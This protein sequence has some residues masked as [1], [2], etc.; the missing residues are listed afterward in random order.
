MALFCNGRR[1]REQGA[2]NGYCTESFHI[3][4]IKGLTGFA[5]SAV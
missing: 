4:L 1:Q 2:K 5:T 3:N